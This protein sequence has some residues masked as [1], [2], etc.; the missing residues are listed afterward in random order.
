MSTIPNEPVG[1]KS[2][3]ELLMELES[4][5]AQ[6]FDTLRSQGIDAER[7]QAS[8]FTGMNGTFVTVVYRPIKGLARG[9][10][11]YHFRSADAH[12]QFATRDLCLFALTQKL[13]Q[14]QE[15]S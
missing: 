5:A 14:L 9:D 10:C 7:G 8:F 1:T 6:A 3:D 15:V 2:P 12:G 13:R 11:T 4:R